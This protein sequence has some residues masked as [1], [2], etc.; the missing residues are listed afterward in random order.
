VA[1]IE[2][3]VVVVVVVIID[4]HQVYRIGFKTH[5][6][7][8]LINIDRQHLNNNH[9]GKTIIILLLDL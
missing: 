6:M 4:H 9:H 5:Q 1:I 7:Q 3:S 2:V 8:L